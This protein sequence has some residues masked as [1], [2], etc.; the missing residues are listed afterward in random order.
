MNLTADP[1]PDYFFQNL[2]GYIAVSSSVKHHALPTA[3]FT[4]VDLGRYSQVYRTSDISK[5]QD[6]LSAHVDAPVTIPHFYS[7]DAPLTLD[8]LAPETH[9]MLAAR[10][11]E[12]YRHLEG[13]FANP[14]ITK[15]V[16]MAA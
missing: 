10:L 9:R 4:G 5:L 7:S 15:H 1:D 11:K 16:S 6:D 14:F 12:E 13:Y 3:V 2:C 8:D